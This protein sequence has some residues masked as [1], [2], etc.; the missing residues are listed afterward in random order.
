MTPHV[1]ELK[2]QPIE[3]TSLALAIKQILLPHLY[4]R[5]TLIPRVPKVDY[6]YTLSFN[7]RI[8]YHLA[9]YLDTL[10]FNLRI[11]Y[12]IHSAKMINNS[13]SIIFENSNNLHCLKLIFLLLN[14]ILKHL[15]IHIINTMP[16]QF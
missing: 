3:D 15:I 5:A 4:L 8:Y 6:L 10:S 16:L 2:S 7:L 11:Y 13:H 12:H 14:T 1:F 9:D